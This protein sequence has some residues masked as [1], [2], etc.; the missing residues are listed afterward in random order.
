M[1]A[2]KAA[3]ARKMTQL[4]PLT[5]TGNSRSIDSRTPPAKRRELK[6]IATTNQDAQI[7]S[8]HLNRNSAKATVG[9]G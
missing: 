4:S 7:A 6:I 2:T 1:S 9:E 3:R 5:Q 8:G